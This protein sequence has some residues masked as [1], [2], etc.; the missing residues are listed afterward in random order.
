MELAGQML[1]FFVAGVTATLV[2][3]L[4]YNGFLRYVKRGARVLASICSVTVAMLTSFAL[5]RLWVFSELS[6]EGWP[7]VKFLAVTLISAYGIQSLVIYFLSR[8][9][10]P[11]VRLNAAFSRVMNASEEDVADFIERNVVKAAAIGVG[12]IW[13]FSWYRLYVFA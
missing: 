3:F 2:D 4:G 13:N 9:W 12:L 11:P 5:N 10:R 8:V 1:R 7:I 6:P